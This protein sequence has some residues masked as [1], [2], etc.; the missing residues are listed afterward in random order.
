VHVSGRRS[1]LLAAVGLV[2]LAGG[3][4]AGDTVRPSFDRASVQAFLSRHWRRPIAPQGVPPAR[5]SPLEASLAPESCGTCHA[6]QFSDWRTAYHAKSMGP[7]VMG[8]LAELWRTDAES[9]RLCLTCH[10][11]LAE[12]QPENRAI[13]DAALNRQGTVCAACHVREHQRFGPPRREQPAQAPP[14]PASLPHGGVT[15]TPAFLASEFCSS[16]HQFENDGFA[17]NGKLLENTYEEWK[18]SPAA[19]RGLQCQDCHMPDRRHLWR[20]I[21]DPEMVR[22]GVMVNLVTDRPH[23]RPGDQVAARITLTANGVGHHFPTYV[24]PRV[25]VRAVLVEPGGREAPGSAEERFIARDVSLDLSRELF[26][27]RIPAG[28]QFVFEYRRRVERTGM[29]LRVHVTVHPDHFYTRFFESL[30]ASG[31]GQGR[32]EIQKALEATRRSTFELY[33]RAVPLT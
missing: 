23:Y 7:G 33:S 4:A 19:S 26:D 5:F 17:L 16:C 2:L 8:Q 6:A 15:R 22:S 18:A 14:A 24:T 28:R 32:A 1:P 9:A 25:V 21:H 12:Q 29:S 3:A 10:A 11:P 31:A 13:F 20:G 27:T 30:L